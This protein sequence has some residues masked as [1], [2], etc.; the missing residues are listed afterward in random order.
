M[1]VNQLAGVSE[2]A[3]TSQNSAVGSDK[4]DYDAFMQLLVAELSNQDPTKPMDS[5]EY[6]SQLATF[7]QVEQSVQTNAKLDTM[8][9]RN[10]LMLAESL[11][12]NTVTASDGLQTGTIKSVR[13]TDD[14]IVATMVD[15]LEIP[16]EPGVTIA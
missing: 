16:I 2:R 9:A 10:E 11:I 4:V 3:T 12:G 7:S 6:V 13:L 15:G 14:G 5:T 8:I 1:Q